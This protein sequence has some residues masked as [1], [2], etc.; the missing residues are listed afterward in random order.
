[1]TPDRIKIEYVPIDKL[2]ELEYNPRKLTSK[3]FADIANSLKSFNAVTPAVVNMRKDRKYIVIGGNQRV[4]IA[5]EIGWEEFPCVFVDLD[6]KDEK[7]LSIRL[8]KNSAEWD[9]DKLA[10]FFEVEELVEWGFSES[11]LVGLFDTPEEEPDTQAE[12]EP[13]YPIV[14]KYDEKHS[15]IMIYVDNEMDLM[16]IRKILNLTKRKCYKMDN[17]SLTMVISGSELIE[18]LKE[19]TDTDGEIEGEIEEI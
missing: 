5:K 3:Q 18:S 10:N 9:F 12:E 14:P 13:E 11:E 17:N 2:K 1:M 7:E 19:I 6:H 15:A 8:N 16:Y 4:K